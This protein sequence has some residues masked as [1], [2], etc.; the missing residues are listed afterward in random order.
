MGKIT[1]GTLFMKGN[2][3]S[4]STAPGLNYEVKQRGNQPNRS[5]PTG[6]VVSVEYSHFPESSVA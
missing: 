2:R 6:V 1:E 3:K 4:R 5:T